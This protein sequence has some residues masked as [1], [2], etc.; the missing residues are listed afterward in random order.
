MNTTED[1]GKTDALIRDLEGLGEAKCGGCGG[2]LG[3]HA[4]VASV[5]LGFKDRPRCAGC[6]AD[7]LGRERRAFLEH[8]GHY[9][10][11][12]VCFRAG[13]EWSDRHLGHGK[14]PEPGA[15]WLR[16]QSGAGASRPEPEPA[17][18]GGA[19]AWD[20]GDM[21]CGDLVLELRRRVKALAPGEV[22]EVRALDH[23]APED[24][25]AWC[26]LTGNR[27]LRAEPPRYWIERKKDE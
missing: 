12:R 4:F 27:L 15:R 25:P 8:L 2:D 7:A 26:G 16:E 19:R 3:P 9:I 21:G 10:R 23:G 20:A 24:L 18:G 1:D 22:L 14:E 11:S 6:L 5:A 17:A 13:W